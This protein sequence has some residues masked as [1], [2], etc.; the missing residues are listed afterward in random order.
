IY[1][2]LGLLL[3]RMQ[4]YEEAHRSFE[5][6]IALEPGE[7]LFASNLS[8]LRQ[9]LEKANEAAQ[10]QEGAQALRLQDT[11]GTVL[12]EVALDQRRWEDM[13]TAYIPSP[14]LF[15]AVGDWL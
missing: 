11:Q 7:A 13:E 6:A 3:I 15:R 4:C 2:N 12:P 5:R 1:N 10:A 8:Q 14:S 9:E